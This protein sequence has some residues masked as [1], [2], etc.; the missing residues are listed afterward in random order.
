MIQ[1]TKVGILIGCFA[2]RIT[3]VWIQITAEKEYVQ[4]TNY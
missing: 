1:A 4:D 2:K 3:D